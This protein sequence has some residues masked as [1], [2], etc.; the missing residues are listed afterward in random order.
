MTS[1]LDKIL[2]FQLHYYHYYYYIGVYILCGCMCV[3][4]YQFRVLNTTTTT[5]T[6]HY[7]PQKLGFDMV[8]LYCPFEADTTSGSMGQ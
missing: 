4:C 6:N 8:L 2:I 7:I 1:E 5:T 3:F